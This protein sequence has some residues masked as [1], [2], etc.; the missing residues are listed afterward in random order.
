MES[1]VE[2]IQDLRAF[3]Q[4]ELDLA[5]H[6]KELSKSSFAVKAMLDDR[7]LNFSKV[8][9]E[10]F[11]LVRIH[12]GFTATKHITPWLSP[13]GFDGNQYMYY[14]KESIDIKNAID[15]ID[16]NSH[17]HKMDQNFFP[18]A[19]AF[20]LI[21]NKRQHFKGTDIRN[22]EDEQLEKAI[23]LIRFNGFSIDH[24]YQSQ[25]M[26]QFNLAE[27]QT[28]MA[29]MIL[30]IVGKKLSLTE[31]QNIF[32]GCQSLGSYSS[33]FNTINLC[34]LHIQLLRSGKTKY[35]LSKE[36]AEIL[37]SKVEPFLRDHQ[38]LWACTNLDTVN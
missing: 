33:A 6:L 25:F 27:D 5:E 24:H 20:L 37:K 22:I 8:H 7:Q 19:L 16:R 32:S 13:L 26:P 12:L 4:H 29:H 1:K 14:S 36:L 18:K 38:S 15:C 35:T 17:F 3:I 2:A 23:S 31:V 30:S 28:G 10:L 34:G 9:K 11:R 21:L